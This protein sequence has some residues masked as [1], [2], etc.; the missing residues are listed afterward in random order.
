MSTV[1]N[2]PNAADIGSDILVAIGQSN[3]VGVGTPIDPVYFETLDSRIRQYP[4]S[5]SFQ[6]QVI[7]GADPL[8]HY[9]GAGNVSPVTAFAKKLVRTSPINRDLLIVPAAIGG[10]G[11]STNSITPTPAGYS[12]TATGT[13][14][15]GGSGVNLYEFAIAQATAA[16]ALNPNNRVVAFFW[17]QGE[18]DGSLGYSQYTTYLLQMID[19]LRSRILT[20]QN[21]IFITGSILPEYVAANPS[22]MPAIQQA[23]TDIPTQRFGCGHALDP[24]LGYVWTADGLNIHY[25]PA[26]ARLL[27]SN[28][29]DAIPHARANQLTTPPVTPGALTF[30]QSGTSVN[31][32]WV[33][34]MGRVTG[35]KIEANTNSAGWTTTVA[36]TAS[37]QN[38]YTLNNLTLGQTL[39]VRVS[40]INEQG[41]SS[42]STSSVFTL[43]TVPAQPT[44]VTVTAA[45]SGYE[46]LGWDPSPGGSGLATSWRIDYKLHSSGTWTSGSTVTSNAGTIYSLNP[47][48]SYDFRITAIN[49]AGAST[50]SAT[51]TNSTA[52]ATVLSSDV[53]INPYGAWSLRKVVSSYVGNAINVRRSS[54]NTTTDIGF[55]GSGNLDATSL[56]TFVGSGNGF[57]VTIYDQS[58]NSRNLTQAN[59]TRQPQIVASGTDETEGGRVALLFVGAS[60]QWLSGAFAGMYTAGAGTLLEVKQVK[61]SSTIISY[62]EE[63]SGGST[64]S[65]VDW[66]NAGTPTWQIKDDSSATIATAGGTGLSAD[67]NIHQFSYMDSGT[68]LNMWQNSAQKLGPTTYN[69]TGHTVTLNRTSI[70]AWQSGGANGTFPFDGLW[71]EAVVWSSALTTP[72]RQSGESN[73]KSYYGTP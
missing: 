70:G 55:D 39:Q 49:S 61:A 71:S 73:Q 64:Q 63:N 23:L 27:G 37:Y 72:Q 59:T 62:A 11:F 50:A 47:S 36:N 46:T 56:N 67:G 41:T 40:A 66:I 28:A 25:N 35:Y 9:A 26:G 29:G 4:G 2:G 14:R 43:A 69:R 48:I 68:Q 18:A 8:F 1:I 20:A 19:G 6:N 13:W 57:V 32:I 42:P 54:D 34:S 3:A 30:S 31:V 22:F 16:V 12:T 17:I 60:T 38:S 24:G 7:S 58:G 10:T 51:L 5:G 65:L 52:S 15:V 21:A 44:N 53:G 33:R 45:G